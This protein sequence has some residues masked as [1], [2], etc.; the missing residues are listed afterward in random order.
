MIKIHPLRIMNVSRKF[1]VNPS[2][3]CGDVSVWAKV[4]DDRWSSVAKIGKYLLGFL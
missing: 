1:H 4:V 2:D 3:V